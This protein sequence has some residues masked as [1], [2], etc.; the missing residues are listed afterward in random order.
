M[1][2]SPTKKHVPDHCKL[3]ISN[4]EI[5]QVSHTK[6]LGV[7][8]DNKLNWGFHINYI[9]S[10]IAKAVG[11]LSKARKYISTPYLLT[12]YYAFLYPYLNYCIEVWGSAATTRM[13]TLIKLQKAS[14]RIITSSRY[15]DHTAPLFQKL[16]ILPIDKLYIWKVLIFMY[17]FHHG[18]QPPVLNHMFIRNSAMH[19]YD[20]RGRN[21]FRTPSSKLKCL[22]Q[23][24]KVKGVFWWNSIAKEIDV[25]CSISLFKKNTKL[26]MA[27]YE[28]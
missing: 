5:Q 24:I 18:L 9:K 1:I 25:D 7:M 16:G 14:V 6:F 12:L 19:D 3:Y 20:T 11:I 22:S 4:D 15:R 27:N 2:F 28:L 10:K 8:I 17:K 26:F 13:Q 21:L 23:T